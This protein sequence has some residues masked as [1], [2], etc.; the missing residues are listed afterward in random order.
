VDR[1]GSRANGG[2]ATRKGA[3]AL[4]LLPARLAPIFERMER[5]FLDLDRGEYDRR[6][7]VAMATV[8]GVLLKIVQAGELEERVRAMEERLSHSQSQESA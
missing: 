1:S 5:V 3:R 2:H 4:R 6:D 8:A 7:A